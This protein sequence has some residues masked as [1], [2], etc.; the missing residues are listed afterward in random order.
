MVLTLP[1]RQLILL[2]LLFPPIHLAGEPVLILF[3]ISRFDVG[4]ITGNDGVRSVARCRY[5][6]AASRARRWRSHHR[7]ARPASGA[8]ARQWSAKPACPAA[9]ASVTIVYVQS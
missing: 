9:A 7:R 2:G 6:A 1:G 5:L 3:D 8:T 4:R